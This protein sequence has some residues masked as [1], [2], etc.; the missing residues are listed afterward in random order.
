[1]S[2]GRNRGKEKG[3]SPVGMP[4]NRLPIVSTGIA[5][6]TTIRVAANSATIVPG[7]RRVILGHNKIMASDADESAR[8]GL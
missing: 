8:V 7:M 6:T 3:G 1:M 2:S 4:P 5:N